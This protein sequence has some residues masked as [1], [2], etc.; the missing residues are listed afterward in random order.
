MTDPDG[1]AGGFISRWQLNLNDAN[2]DILQAIDWNLL[3][4]SLLRLEPVPTLVIRSSNAVAFRWLLKTVTEG[5]I[6]GSV[7]LVNQLRLFWDSHYWENISGTEIL[8]SEAHH[9]ID[10]T[11]VTPGPIERFELLLR[12]RTPQVYGDPDSYLAMLLH[13]NTQ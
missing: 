9:V 10:E 4:T 3:Q 11:L 5:D 2:V 8:S 6:L 7:L 13:K 1:L 12:M